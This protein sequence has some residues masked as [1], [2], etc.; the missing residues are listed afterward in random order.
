MKEVSEIRPTHA[1]VYA[2]ALYPALAKE[3][4]KLG[5]ALAVHGSVAR[6]LDV[7]AVPWVESVAE[8][9]EVIDILEKRFAVR[10]IGAPEI[11]QH[12]RLCYT[13]SVGFGECAL[14]FSFFPAPKINTK[15]P[16]S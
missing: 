12:G 1:P 5:Y 8:P 3:C 15:N 4:L 6:D 7:V 9:Q 10:Q 16:L 14:D 13:L 2:A 11:K